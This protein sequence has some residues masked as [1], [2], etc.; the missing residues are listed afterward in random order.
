MEGGGPGLGVMLEL[1]IRN[2][3]DGKKVPAGRERVLISAGVLGCLDLIV[4]IVCC[5]QINPAA[6]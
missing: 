6:N 4:S 5:A 3:V 2:I 1:C